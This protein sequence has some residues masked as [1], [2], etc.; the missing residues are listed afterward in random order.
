VIS[1]PNQDIFQSEMFS[2]I[3]FLYFYGSIVAVKQLAYLFL[4]DEST[5][6]SVCVQTRCEARVTK[7]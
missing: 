7:P 1:L 4:L 2:D 6:A 3:L 5:P